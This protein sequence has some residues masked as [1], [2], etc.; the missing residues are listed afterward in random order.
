[1]ARRVGSP[2]GGILPLSSSDVPSLGRGPGS[3]RGGSNTQSSIRLPRMVKRIFRPPTLDFETA[4]WEIVYLVISPRKVYKS[5]YYQK[6]TKNTWARDDPSFIILLCSF[7][8]VSAI[9]W[10]LAY[11][12][13][14]LPII[15][16]MFYMVGV[17]FFLAGLIISTIAWGLAN[18][19][20]KK[21]SNINNNLGGQGELEWAYC[22]DVHCNAFLLIWICL[23]VVEFLLLPILSRTNWISLFLGNTLYLIALTFYFYITFLGYSSMPFLEHTE[24]FL[25]PIIVVFILYFGSLFGF[26]IV[27]HMLELYFG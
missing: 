2:G 5:L 19:F 17:D 10:G 27:R 22:F 16:L 15:K 21:Q 8:V 1:M 26:S 25:F 7:L 3:R 11:S 12:P 9:G 13:G 14:F 4:I 6:Q 23:Y 20:L 18:R 24:I